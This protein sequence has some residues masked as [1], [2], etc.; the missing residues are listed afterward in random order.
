MSHKRHRFSYRAS[1]SDWQRQ[2]HRRSRSVL[3]RV[4]S[5]HTGT[6]A[7]HVRSAQASLA[8]GL[9]QTFWLSRETRAVWRLLSAMRFAF[10]ACTDIFRA[11][12]VEACSQPRTP[13]DHRIRSQESQVRC[14][15]EAVAAGSSPTVPSTLCAEFGCADDIRGKPEAASTSLWGSV[16]GIAGT[17]SSRKT[18]RGAHGLGEAGAGGVELVAGSRVAQDFVA[19]LLAR[20][21]HQQEHR[22]VAPGVFERKQ[23]DCEPPCSL[24]AANAHEAQSEHAR[25]A[26]S[27]ALR[28]SWNIRS[29]VH[30]EFSFVDSR[31]GTVAW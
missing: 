14:R 26:A 6:R 8:R 15:S 7:V 19:G 18:R 20:I 11:S 24:S 3:C 1:E 30:W 12:N 9:R 4:G 10:S 13:A 21:K 27:G 25:V 16:T 23:P 5:A 28:D 29:R 17:A 31:L 22:R 2:Q